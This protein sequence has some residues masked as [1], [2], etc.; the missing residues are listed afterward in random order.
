MKTTQRILNVLMVFL[1]LVLF[2]S[3]N[4][5]NESIIKESTSMNFTE[6]TTTF[7]ETMDF[8]D[9]KLIDNEKSLNSIKNVY[10]TDILEHWHTK[11]YSASVSSWRGLFSEIN[12]KL[13]IEIL[14]KFDDA[15]Y[16]A[17]CKIE[18]GGLLYIF[19]NAHEE[20]KNTEP[21]FTNSV[22]SEKRLAKQDFEDISI[23]SNLYDVEAIDPATRFAPKYDDGT[24]ISDHLLTDGLMRF[25]YEKNG[26]SYI[27]E[28]K[29]YYPIKTLED[30]EN[31]F[32]YMNSAV[33]EQDRIK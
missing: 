11:T 27:V 16:Y 10:K 25:I 33:L 28:S 8:F 14:R 30:N 13:P 7:K 1:F 21:V 24:A 9:V 4:D 19:F 18:T 5:L 2:S 12:A 29:Y 22:Y 15:H 20:D 26:D 17:I 32:I 6:N 23:G 3:C 31:G